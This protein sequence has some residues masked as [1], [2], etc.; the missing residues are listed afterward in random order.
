MKEGSY[1]KAVNFGA[2]RVSKF[3]PAIFADPLSRI[4]GC[5]ASA[6]GLLTGIHPRRIKEPPRED[7]TERYMVRFLRE[8]GFKVASLTMRNLTRKKDVSYPIGSRHVVLASLKFIKGEA[9]WVVIY[10]GIM[11]HGFEILSFKSYELINHPVR[12]AFLVKHKKW[13]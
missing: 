10:N 6:L 9:S 1:S 2:F 13:D 5:G 3:T 8:H 7:W 4:Y 12:S 11:F